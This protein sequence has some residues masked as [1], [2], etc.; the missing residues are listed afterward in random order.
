MFGLMTALVLKRFYF[1]YETSRTLA[2]LQGSHHPVEDFFG[3]RPAII[4]HRGACAPAANS[5]LLI[6]NTASGIKEAVDVGVD[7][8]EIDLRRSA[9]K[10]L[11]VFHDDRVDQKTS[12][13]GNVSDLDLA[14][15]KTLKI[16]VDADEEIMSLNEVF[17]QFHSPQQK[18][19]FDIKE[20]GIRAEVVN[21]LKDR[22]SK[23]ELN[24]DQVILFGTDEVLEQYRESGYALGYV[25]NREDKGNWLRI[26]FAQ[27]GITARCVNLGCE[28]LV[29]PSTFA[30]SSLLQAAESLNLKVLIY[31]TESNRDLIFFAKRRVA[32]FIVDKPRSAVRVFEHAVTVGDEAEPAQD[33]A[34]SAGNIEQ[35]SVMDDES[36]SP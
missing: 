27:S 33:E 11:V 24:T 15:L 26:L 22:V 9:D 6:G 21:W 10:Q 17:D 16:L 25:A 23:L 8:I 1:S 32:G 30:S 35:E 2:W 34:G 14:E 31:G 4:G 19:I 20:K 12:G 28:Y 29:I 18:W 3:N 5:E 7:W 13:E 36:S